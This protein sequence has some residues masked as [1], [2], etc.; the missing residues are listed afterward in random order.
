MPPAACC[1]RGQ[2]G[3]GALCGQGEVA[4]HRWRKSGCFDPFLSFF[5]FKTNTRQ[6]SVLRNKMQAEEMP[7]QG[8]YNPDLVREVQEASR[9][10]L[11]GCCQHGAAEERAPLVLLAAQRV[12]G[13]TGPCF[14][15][16][17]FVI[18]QPVLP[19][20]LVLWFLLHSPRQK[21]EAL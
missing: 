21:D 1:V 9:A 16:T 7:N 8:L 17:R 11:R 18:F 19:G 20:S 12:R 6:G 4:L 5:L 13:R 3:N 14:F 10:W 2:G 15:L